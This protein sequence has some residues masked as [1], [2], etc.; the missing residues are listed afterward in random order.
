MRA[1]A[2]GGRTPAQLCSSLAGLLTPP[3]QACHPALHLLHLSSL[4]ILLWCF[5]QEALQTRPLEAVS[6]SRGRRSDCLLLGTQELCCAQ[7]G[8]LAHPPFP[9]VQALC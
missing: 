2:L 7:S 5:L 4:Q 6:T 8:P 1:A 9:E 3:I